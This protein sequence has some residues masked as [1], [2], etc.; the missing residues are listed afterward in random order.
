ML[1]PL[2]LCG[3]CGLLAALPF[4]DVDSS[5]SAWVVFAPVFWV[6]ARA[7][8][9]K[10]AAFYAYVFALV[11][12]S[13]SFTFMWANAFEGAIAA[14]L[15][16]AFVYMLALL[17][18]RRLARAGGTA[19]VFGV[20]A[21][22][23]LAEI[24]RSVIPILYFPWL[25]LGHTLWVNAPLRQGADVLGVYGLSFLIAVFN[26][27]L[28]FAL[29]AAVSSFFR[30]NGAGAPF[31][32]R[33]ESLK[34]AW[35][36]LSILLAL[37]GGFFFYGYERIA[38][39]A[40]RLK[41][42]ATIAVIQGNVKTKLGRTVEMLNEQTIRHLELHRQVVAEITAHEGKPPALVC[43]AETMVPGSMYEDEWGEQFQKEIAKVGVP[44]LAGSNF[45]EPDDRDKAED[46]KRTHNAAF[47]FD[48]KG[49]E[50]LR[51]C[52]RRL[53][54]FGEYVPYGRVSRIMGW[55]RSVTQ[56]RYVPGTECSEV[57]DI[58]GYHIAL[59]ICVEDTHPA[60]ARED[61]FHGADTLVNI[62]NDGWFYGTYGPRSHLQAAMWRAIETRR[63]LLRVTNTGRT[64]A[65]D[66][67][68]NIELIL[69]PETEAA[70][71]AKLMRIDGGGAQ[72]VTPY[73]RLG[74]FWTAV[75]FGLVLCVSVWL[76]PKQ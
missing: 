48:A 13:R 67:L 75:I 4:R 5:L 40:P 54:P 25:L 44:T 22:W 24:V 32:G 55:I 53:V 72:I 15:Y 18:V 60:I 35:R 59:N 56:D 3:V 58:G 19:A 30:R 20:A 33:D 66:P 42:G 39:I 14:A 11:W 68:G 57:I 8:S 69:P 65:V 47:I 27:W 63:P 64:V 71:L 26:A 50:I 49:K 74:E 43:W 21:A 62:T 7:K 52:K 70:G 17:C 16:T 28:A 41:P 1:G 23:V 76:S 2:A 51:Y 45:L 37:I 61:A 12:T 6:V 9:K 36:S 38:R 10:A 46:E 73:M 34:H 29:P 31:Y